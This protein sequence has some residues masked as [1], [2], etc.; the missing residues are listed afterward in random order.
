MSRTEW[1]HLITEAIKDRMIRCEEHKISHILKS[2]TMSQIYN[3]LT[4]CGIAI[5]PM[6]SVISGGSAGEMDKK[7]TGV[8]AG[9]G[10]LSGVVV[11]VIKFGKFDESAIKHKNAADGYSELEDEIRNQLLLEEKDRLSA[12]DYME[13]SQNKFTALFASSPLLGA[14]SYKVH[15]NSYVYNFARRVTE[16]P[17]VSKTTIEKTNKAVAA[18]K[19]GKPIDKSKVVIQIEKNKVVIPSPPSVNKIKIKFESDT[20]TPSTTVFSD[21]ML[22]YELERF[23]RP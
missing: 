13:W 2:G 15:D 8:I 6:I 14:H 10:I 1:T 19:A 21:K 5:G 23:R 22:Q 17:H 20:E 11:S 18:F 3:A 4:I 12:K 7:L 16:A 9:L